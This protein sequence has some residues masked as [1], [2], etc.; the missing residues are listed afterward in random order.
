LNEAFC[1]EILFLYP[2]LYAACLTVSL[3]EVV[4]DV[5]PPPPAFPVDF[6][7]LQVIKPTDPP[8]A[9]PDAAPTP[10]PTGVDTTPKGPSA[11]PEAPAIVPSPVPKT[12]EDPAAVVKQRGSGGVGVGRTSTILFTPFPI[13]SMISRTSP[14]TDGHAGL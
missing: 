14:P 2:S 8:I 5:E 9:K 4:A 11:N 7:K 1:G 10:A 3:L 13:V 6:M 12:I